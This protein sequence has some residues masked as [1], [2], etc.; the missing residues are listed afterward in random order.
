MN[1]SDKVSKFFTYG[2]V[3]FYETAKRYHIDNTPTQEHL[4][5]LIF[6]ATHIAD[7]CRE[8]VGG[9]L[10]G[11]FYRCPALNMLLP[12]ADPT[13]FHQ[14]GKAVDLDCDR[15]GYGNNKSLFD[16]VRTTMDFDKLIWEHGRV[17]DSNY[18]TIPEAH[19]NDQLDCV[20][21]HGY[22]I[23]G[24]LFIPDWVHVQI[25][26]TGTNRKKVV[27]RYQVFEDGKYVKD[28]S[29]PFDLY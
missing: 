2:E 6:T 10:E 19:L 14:Y 23:P 22:V 28:V 8:F 27:R 29:I 12:G 18:N 26:K 20:D 16:R 5:N 25:N 11:K 3:I 15:Y 7:P 21:A 1:L 24:A 17:V 9:P 4:D 13:S